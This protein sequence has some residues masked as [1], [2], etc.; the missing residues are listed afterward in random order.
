MSSKA[1][2]FIIILLIKSNINCELMIN[3]NID[4]YQIKMLSIISSIT[5]INKNISRNPMNYTTLIN[6]KTESYLKYNHPIDYSDLLNSIALFLTNVTNSNIIIEIDDKCTNELHDLI[7]NKRKIINI[8]F[9]FSGKGPN[10]IGGKKKCEAN[11]ELFLLFDY[12]VNPELYYKIRNVRDIFLFQMPLRYYTGMCLP[13]SCMSFYKRFFSNKEEDNKIFFDYMNSIGI[14]SL[15]LINSDEES[16]SNLNKQ[17]QIKIVFIIIS[18]GVLIYIIF[19]IVNTIIYETVRSYK[20]NQKNDQL[21]KK[22]KKETEREVYD[23]FILDGNNN[24]FDKNHG[25]STF[26][27]GNKIKKKSKC[28]MF[29]KLFN[30]KKAIVNIFIVKSRV[31]DLSE[32]SFIVLMRY[33]SIIFITIATIFEVLLKFPSQD[34]STDYLYAY[35]SFSIIK[36]STFWKEIFILIEGIY[37]GFKLFN[38]IKKNSANFELTFDLTWRF[39]IKLLSRMYSFYFI[40]I[41]FYLMIIPLGEALNSSDLLLYYI[42]LYYENKQ[43]YYNPISL[44]Y[45]FNIHYKTSQPEE[46]ILNSQY[47]EYDK[48]Y[49]SGKS[50]LSYSCFSFYLFITN[51]LISIVATIFLTFLFMKIKKILVEALFMCLI[52]INIL[53]IYYYFN[54]YD[55]GNIPKYTSILYILGEK[56]TYHNTHLFFSTFQIGYYIGIIIFYYYDIVVNTILYAIA[57]GVEDDEESYFKSKNNNQKEDFNESN[58]FN[59]IDNSIKD[60]ID[61]SSNLNPLSSTVRKNNDINTI[62]EESNQV[63]KKEIK[64]EGKLNKDY[65][66]FYP[67][68]WIMNFLSHQAKEVWIVGGVVCFIILVLISISQYIYISINDKLS[69]EISTLMKIIYIYERKIFLFIIVFSILCKYFYPKK[70]YIKE[71]DYENKIL[72]L[73]ERVSFSYFCLL[74]SFVII[75]FNIIEMDFRMNIINVILFSIGTLLIGNIL[76]VLITLFF[77]YPV[78]LFIFEYSKRKI[79]KY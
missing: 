67:C 7:H 16:T 42:K 24:I 20:Y 44:C 18:S 1:L 79:N 57:I 63:G 52:I 40:L 41:Y 48:E 56:L 38:Y 61:G 59:N 68:F 10:Q 69:I 37:L 72:F 21:E 14:Y 5:E 12:K 6:N 36:F 28:L 11:Q 19:S 60:S 45:F 58:D 74:E 30:I 54:I 64:K 4:P 66:P 9:A 26:L 17:N 31:Y 15:K 2:Y 55:D 71:K 47:N 32:L 43:C 8:I 75:L 22:L 39:C 34:T 77:E 78:R 50:Y 33:F 27:K 62:I 46:I 25:M 51:L 65:L 49:I 53:T 23:I 29:M 13:I 73:F 35:I 76:S 70:T 3:Q